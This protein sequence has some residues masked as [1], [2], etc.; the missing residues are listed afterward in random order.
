MAQ[1]ITADEAAG[2]IHDGDSVGVSSFTALSMAEDIFVAIRDRFVREQHPRDLSF[3]HVSGVGDYKAD[4]RGLNHLTMDGLIKRIYGAHAAPYPALSPMM[5][6]GR[7][8]TYMVPQGVISHLY[9]AMAAG[10]KGLLTRIGLH[11]YCDPRLGGCRINDNSKEDIVELV[12]INGEEMLYYKAFPLN[13]CLLKGSLADEDGNISCENEPL[14][15]EQL[16]VAAATHRQGGK[17]VVVVHKVVKKGTLHP[18]K[19]KIPSVLVD[20]VVVGRKENTFQTHF[21]DEEKPE[22]TGDLQIS[23]ND[24]EPMPFGVRKIV[25]RRGALEIHEGMFV[26]VG[27]G[28]PEGVA[29]VAAEEG[30]SDKILLGVESGL[31]GGVPVRGAIGTAYN[32]EVVLRQPECFDLYNGGLLDMSFL[33]CA[34][35]SPEGNVNVSKFSGKVIGPGGFINITEATPR[36]C[37]V[38]TFTGGKSDIRIENG[39]LNIVRDGKYV[40]FVNKVEQITFSGKDAVNKGQEV[41]YI[42]ER[43]VF[44][45][46]DKGIMLTEIA[47]GVDIQKNI[48]DKMEFEPVISPDLKTMDP[49]LF[50]PELM[51]LSKSV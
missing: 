20:Y 49:R 3:Y 42:T 6:D 31:I 8:E 28:M 41:L 36:I 32:P 30:I 10:E 19:I 48:L 26:N 14:L 4:G 21:F 9:R 11:T 46:T 47:P 40:K 16:E 43:A 5:A 1:F 2:L 39:R 38:G 15:L 45:L 25:A 23:V 22:L 27:G 13:I 51:G 35:I 17:V 44:K 50:E 33:G 34:E 37:Y 24:I 18:R 29:N 7:I 12:N